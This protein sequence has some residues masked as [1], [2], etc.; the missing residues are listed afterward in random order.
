MCSSDLTPVGKLRTFLCNKYGDRTFFIKGTT[1]RKI[2]KYSNHWN[3]DTCYRNILD[4]DWDKKE[5]WRKAIQD[6]QYVESELFKK[7]IKDETNVEDSYGFKL[8]LEQEKEKAIKQRQ[9]RKSSG[10]YKRLNKT[11]EQVTIAKAQPSMRGGYK[12]EKEV[13]DVEIGRAHV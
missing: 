5:D 11:K 7:C 9:E 8:F 10:N 1:N 6:W 13:Y 4:L 2:G 3:D 12:F